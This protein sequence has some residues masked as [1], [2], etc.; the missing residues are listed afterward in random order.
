MR[1]S[2]LIDE[3]GAE[4]ITQAVQAAEANT[5]GEILVSVVARSDRHA[6]A[7]WRMGV[8]LAATTFFALHLAPIQLSDA[9]L[10]GAQLAAIALGHALTRIAEIRR[11]FVSEQECT[12]AA[13]R[14]AQAE[15]HKHGIRQTENQTGI[16]IFV[17]LL[18]HR[19][20]V[21]AD[22]A[23]DRVL[24][25]EESWEEVVEL[26]LGGIR[27][28]DITS[29]IERAVSRCGEILAHPLPIQPD[30]RDEIPNAVVLRD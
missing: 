2:Q 13:E 30:D 4:R 10:F 29:G 27:A 25:P 9:A 6:A 24:D 28:G 21:L 15:F 17:S 5:A 26:V 14:E 12:E 1:P 22:E 8:L 11:L 7:P 19:V 20:V 23:I 18:E 3:A 16:L